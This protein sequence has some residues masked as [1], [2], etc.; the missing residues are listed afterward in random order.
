MGRVSGKIALVTGGASV[1]GLGSGTAQRLAQEGAVVY[2]TDVDLAGAETVAAGIREAGGQAV[3]LAHDV[4]SEKDW[5]R[6][7]DAMIA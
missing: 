4:T 3:A 1:P 2:V 7:I 6:V 5:D